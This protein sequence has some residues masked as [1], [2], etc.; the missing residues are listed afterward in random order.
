MKILF[1]TT[2]YL[3]KDVSSTIRN[4][5]LVKG[6]IENN[7]SVDVYT[8]KYPDNRLSNFFIK[9]RNGSVFFTELSSMNLNNY[10][11]KTENTYLIKLKRFIQKTIL[12]PDIWFQW[13]REIRIDNINQYDIILSS[14]D[15][16]TSHFVGRKIKN[17]YPSIPWIQIWGDPWYD[18][19]H[20]IR[21]MRP[22]IYY[23]ERRLLKL[24]DASVYISRPTKDKILNRY[25]SFLDKV[26][27]IPRSF[28][29]PVIPSLSYPNKDFHIVY[30]GKLG[31]GRKINTFLQCVDEH[32]NSNHK[33]III[34]FYGQ[35]E[36]NIVEDLT[37]FNCIRFN[38]SIEYDGILTVF[39]VADALL[40]ISNKK[41]S[42]QIPGKLY[43]YLGTSCP[44]LCLV[45]DPEDSISSFLKEHGER[46]VLLKNDINCIQ[47]SFN[48]IIKCFTKKYKP[49]DKYSPSSIAK[50]VLETI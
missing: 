23:Y 17:A 48:L 13:T 26:H 4:N 41:G 30:T 49:I 29:Q 9:E 43:D 27:Y 44:I 8:I 21:W 6:L 3:V 31:T 10:I 50:K 1:I 15:G 39:L 37:K 24:C 46:C 2:C 16:K 11:K 45:Y 38:G 18:D 28:Y 7:H 40:Y 25:P 36:Q 32:N 34:D 20:T 12:F 35:Y 22:I 19:L 5:A 47:Q 42:T 33:K 14:S